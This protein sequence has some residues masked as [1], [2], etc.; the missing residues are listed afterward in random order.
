MEGGTQNGEAFCQKRPQ[1]ADSPRGERRHGKFAANDSPESPRDITERRMNLDRNTPEASFTASLSSTEP[2]SP[3]PRILQPKNPDPVDDVIE[4]GHF[5]SA[6][7]RAS[8]GFGA[9]GGGELVGVQAVIGA[10]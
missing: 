4:V 7:L 6:S 3:S 8:V 10:R 9:L 1:P 2:S 5:L